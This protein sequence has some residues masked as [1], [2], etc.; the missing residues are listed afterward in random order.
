MVAIEAGGSALIEDP[1]GGAHAISE[2]SY[3]GAEKARVT[4]VTDDQ[5]VL[6]YDEVV[7]PDTN[8][9][10]SHIVTLRIQAA[11]LTE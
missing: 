2:G 8:K 11:I 7:D 3:L 4:V 10:R 9:L 6:T 5:V 1:A